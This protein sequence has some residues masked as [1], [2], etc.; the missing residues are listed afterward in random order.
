MI[1]Q[2]QNLAVDLG[3]LAVIGGMI[4]AL[5]LGLAEISLLVFPRK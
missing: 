2:M 1:E 4:T 5:G 3:I